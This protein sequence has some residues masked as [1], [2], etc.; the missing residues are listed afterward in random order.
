[1]LA[2][3]SGRVVMA[4]QMALRGNMVIIDHGGGLLSGYGHMS[5]FA[6][7][8]GQTVQAGDIIGYVGNTGLSTGAHLHWEMAAGGIVVDALR[9]TDGTDGF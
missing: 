1:V 4:R 5:A 2:T 8:E 7:A 3:N 6:V 9:F